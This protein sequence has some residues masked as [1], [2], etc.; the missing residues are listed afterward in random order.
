MIKSTFLTSFALALCLCAFAQNST[1]QLTLDEIVQQHEQDLLSNPPGKIGKE[2]PD[3]HFQRWLWYAKQHTD[4]QGYAVSAQKNYNEW[5][6]LKADRANR[7]TTNHSQADWKQLGA[8]KLSTS[9]IQKGFGLGRVNVVEFHPTTANTYFVGPVN[10]GV[11]KTTN[12][13]QSWT[14]LT[15]DLPVMTVSDIVVNPLNPN[16]IYLCTGDRDGADVNWNHYSMG[17]FKSTDGGQTWSQLGPSFQI[18]NQ[19][20]TNSLLINPSDTNSLTL[21]KGDGI[22]KS[23]N[24][25]TS[26]TNVQSGDFRQL[27]YKPG[28]TS[29]VYATS[30]KGLDWAQVYRSTD[31][32]TSWSQVTTLSESE[33]IFLAVSPADSKVVMALVAEDKTNNNYGGLH[34]L[35]K[36]TNDGASFVKVHE[37]TG[38]NCAGNIL[39]GE[40]DPNSPQCGG[41]GFY[42]ISMAIHPSNINNIY[43]GGVNGWYSTDGGV[44]W[45]N[46]N[47]WATSLPGVA[48]VHADKHWMEFHPLV[49]G[50]LF[51]CND[52][53]VAYTDNPTNKNG[54]WVDVTNGMEITQFYRIAVANTKLSDFFVVGG[55]QDNSVFVI[56]PNDINFIGTGDGTNAQI[57]QV[58][59]VIYATE[60]NGYMHR[61]DAVNGDQIISPTAK[62]PWVTSFQISP[63]NVK[64]LIAGYDTIFYSS[65]QG[66]NW[67]P[68]TNGPLV[69]ANT[70]VSRVEM[71]PAN[72]GTIYATVDGTNDIYYTHNFSVGST[73]SFTKITTPGFDP[74]TDI[75]VDHKDKD[76]FWVTVGGYGSDQV[77][78]YKNGNF[79]KMNTGLPD[80]PVLCIRQDTSNQVLYL[81]TDL[82][83]FFREPADTQW[84]PFDKGLPNV[85]VSDIEINY[86]AKRIYAGTY[87][88]GVWVS[89][90]QG[91]T[92]TSVAT[93]PYAQDV[94]QIVPNPNNGNF[95]VIA[96]DKITTDN[97]KI[98]VTDYTGR[99]VSSVLSSLRN[100]NKLQVNLGDVPAGVYIVE[101]SDRNIILG[102]KRVIVR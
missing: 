14:C 42:D 50:R 40:E 33:R 15:N 17:I 56:E 27:L 36:S 1:K 75:E 96:G 11:W 65:D 97:V 86:T 21:A 73:A 78:E 9:W 85:N 24:G 72:A 26:W 22:F 10:G 47:Q 98:T 66:A 12:N 79:T 74:I 92:A 94:F 43:V 95:E 4:R 84:E 81:G 30:Y 3:A 31:G 57:D 55:A 77:F 80:V 19:E 23:S 67:S 13:G 58:N 68:V 59:E 28:D 82:G 51:E 61:F 89:P 91:D 35:L 25:G 39:S 29:I 37:P 71:T 45:T 34:S 64:H 6:K 87:G 100:S 70:Y 54:M 69:A 49:A 5:K 7:K 2:A 76:H 102:S 62:G 83:M 93:I 53:G 38:A 101:L 60:Q 32:G 46:M 63:F 48:T 41:Q 20:L 90:R 99:V 16:T 88:R 8:D 44:N 18:S 52:G